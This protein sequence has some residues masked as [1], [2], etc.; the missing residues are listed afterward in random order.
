MDLLPKLKRVNL[1]ALLRE[2]V[3]HHKGG[4]LLL[5]MEMVKLGL[6]T[7]DSRQFIV[8]FS[9]MAFLIHTALPLE[10][11]DTEL[12]GHF[13]IEYHDRTWKFFANFRDVD[14]KEQLRFCLSF[15][16]H[17]QLREHL[18]ENVVP[19]FKRPTPLP[20]V[21][22]RD[23]KLQRFLNCINDELKGRFDSFSN[24]RREQLEF[25]VGKHKMRQ[26]E[27]IDNA[28][29]FLYL[30]VGV[31]TQTGFVVNPFEQCVIE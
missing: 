11:L 7:E 18:M 20:I 13:K 29:Y 14:H 5:E 26:E 8:A 12:T 21:T 28:G 9:Y 3:R 4:R 19:A 27:W 25:I 2:E 1:D 16:K 10:Q 23:A 6:P 22:D 24:Y 15:R 31:N 17:V 30:S